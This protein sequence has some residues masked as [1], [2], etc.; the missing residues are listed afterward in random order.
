MS[1]PKDIF[2]L[3]GELRNA[4]YEQYI[5]NADRWTVCFSRGKYLPPPLALA[6]RQIRDE[7]LFLWDKHVPLCDDTKYIPLGLFDA[8][9]RHATEFW[10]KALATMYSRDREFHGVR[11]TLVFTKDRSRWKAKQSCMEYNDWSVEYGRPICDGSDETWEILDHR[12][13]GRL[14][15]LHFLLTVVFEPLLLSR[16]RRWHMSDLVQSGRISVGMWWRGQIRSA[17]RGRWLK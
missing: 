14:R 11:I 4:I 1:G 2:S 5:A 3:P 8:D 15:L 17:K 6:S 13:F 12:P 7:F 16:S 9:I 10:E